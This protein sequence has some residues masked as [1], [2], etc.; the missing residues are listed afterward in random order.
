M[1]NHI[2]PFLKLGKTRYETSGKNGYKTLQK[3]YTALL[4]TPF[5][6]T[7]NPKHDTLEP[8]TPKP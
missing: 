5:I 8:L 1:T 3:P 4:L 6:S 2:Q 7:L